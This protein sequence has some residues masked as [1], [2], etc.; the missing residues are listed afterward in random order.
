MVIAV[1]LQVVQGSILNSDNSFITACFNQL[2]KQH[3]KHSFIYIVDKGFDEKNIQS[4]N[5]TVVVAGPPVKSTLA[6]QYRLQYKIPALLRKHKADIFISEMICSLRTK[7]PQCIIINDLSFLQ[8]SSYLTAGWARFYKNNTA[9]Y[10]DKAAAVITTSLFLQQQLMT[11]YKTAAEKIKVIPAGID[12]RFV[13]AGWEL[14]ESIKEKYAGGK[15]YFLYAGLI[16]PAQ[17]LTNFLKAFS[18]FK[19]RQKSNMQLV[20]ASST[21]TTDSGFIKSLDSFKYRDEVKVFE[22]IPVDELVALT[23]GAYALVYPSQHALFATS[24]TQAMQAAVPVIAGNSAALREIC[25]EAAA[26]INPSDFNDIATKMMWLFKDEDER[27]SL[28]IKGQQK[29]LL[30]WDAVAGKVWKEITFILQ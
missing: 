21:A 2:A 18:F 15:E 29:E 28:I 4:Q 16:H 9:K 19:K 24:V 3:P 14:K 27:N 8:R 6:L 11:H 22:N 20:I 5:I 12:E 10:V 17:E 23:A 7:I 26:G 13:A 25:G 1:N 30:Y